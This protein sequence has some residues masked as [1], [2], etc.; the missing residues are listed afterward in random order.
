[1]TGWIVGDVVD[2]GRLV[3]NRSNAVTFDGAISGTGTL[4]KRGASTLTLTADNSYSGGTRII[5]GTLILGTNGTTGGIVGDVLN[6][7]TLAFNR[8][9]A[10]NFAGA[11]TGTGA[12]D[13]RGDGVT[14]LTGTSAYTGLTTVSSGEL[15][16]ENGGKITA[17][18]QL[19]VAPDVNRHGVLSVDGAGSRL[20]ITGS[21]S[22]LSASSEPGFS[23]SGTGGQ[24]DLGSLNIGGNPAGNGTV[25]VDGDGSSLIVR[26]RDFGF[27]SR[28]C[29]AEYPQWRHSHQY[30]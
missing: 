17:S 7:G 18:S 29:G 15:R 14:T 23:T 27:A 5:A 16:L 2:D 4:E 20:V 25:N 22:T 30:D 19:E 11:I 10:L 28:D 9:N 1:M 8:S 24:A 6:S 21:S 3:F 12:I 26:K 13:Q